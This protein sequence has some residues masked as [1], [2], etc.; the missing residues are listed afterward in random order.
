M[1]DI[2]SLQTSANAQERRAQGNEIEARRFRESAERH[3]AA[4][5]DVAAQADISSAERLEADAQRERAMALAYNNQAEDERNARQ[6]QLDREISETERSLQKL[7]DE[8][9]RL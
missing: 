9:S 2:S 1:P 5:D 4:G 3:A 8:R 7:K 6:Q